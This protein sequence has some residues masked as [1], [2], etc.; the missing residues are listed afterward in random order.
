VLGWNLLG[1]NANLTTPVPLFHQLYLQNGP[2][3]ECTYKIRRNT[4]NTRD[5]LKMVARLPDCSPKTL[6]PNKEHTYRESCLRSKIR[7]EDITKINEVLFIK[8]STD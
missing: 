3:R 6:S 7:T 5:F 8:K 4:N 2:M 1:G